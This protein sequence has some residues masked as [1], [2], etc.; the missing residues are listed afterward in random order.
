[1]VEAN[2]VRDFY[3]GHTRIKIA[4]N[5][6]CDKTQQ[7]IDEILT[8]IAQKAQKHI[9]AAATAGKNE[10]QDKSKRTAA[11][12]V[13]GSDDYSGISSYNHADTQLLNEQRC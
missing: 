8:R 10:G 3:I 1:M 12:S 13:C 2:I 9:N 5:Y 7:D 6:C 4:D 11:E